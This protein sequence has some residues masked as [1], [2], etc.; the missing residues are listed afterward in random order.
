[1]SSTDSMSSIASAVTGGAVVAF[2]DLS[3]RLLLKS[4]P[5]EYEQPGSSSKAEV[6]LVP[7][8]ILLRLMKLL[9]RD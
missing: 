3:L 6:F 9:I 5:R 8:Q 7:V 4:L 1:M 2:L